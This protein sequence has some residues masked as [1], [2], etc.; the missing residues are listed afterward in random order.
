M[1]TFKGIIKG[2]A[3][4][5]GLYGVYKVGKFIYGRFFNKKEMIGN[6]LGAIGSTFQQGFAGVQSFSEQ[7]FGKA[8]KNIGAQIEQFGKATFGVGKMKLAKIDYLPQGGLS[9]Y[10]KHTDNIPRDIRKVIPAIKIPKPDKIKLP[11]W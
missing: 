5:I 11:K 4:V 8:S 7:T 9:I 6:S 10:N 2:F 3:I 1:V